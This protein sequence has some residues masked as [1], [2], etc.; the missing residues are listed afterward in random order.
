[1]YLASFL[2]LIAAFPA[3]LAILYLYRYHG[4]SIG[5]ARDNLLRLSVYFL[6]GVLSDASREFIPGSTLPF[7]G[8][9]ISLGMVILS[10]GHVTAVINYCPDVKSLRD[11]IRRFLKPTLPMFAYYA[12][13]LVA[14]GWIIASLL[15]PVGSSSLLYGDNVYV[16]FV[17][18][19]AYQT[20]TTVILPFLVAYPSLLLVLAI[21]RAKSSSVR[22]SLIVLLAGW[23]LFPTS[24]L[25]LFIQSD[26]SIVFSTEV[27]LLASSTFFLFCAYSVRGGS[28]IIRLLTSQLTPQP[29]LKTGQKYLILHDG[30]K[31]I[32]SFLSAS[33][34]SVIDAGGRV[35]LNMTGLRGGLMDGLSRGQPKFDNWLKSGRIVKWSEPESPKMNKTLTERFSQGPVALTFVTPLET[36]DLRDMRLPG[37]GEARDK[38]Q[39]VSQ[40]YLL[41]SNKAPR[42][43]LTEFLSRNGEVEVMNLSE[44]RD[45]FSTLIKTDH[46]RIQ[47]SRILVEYDQNSNYDDVVGRFFSEGASNAEL[48]AL[49]TAKSSKL[50]RTMKGNKMVKV[51]SA[52]SL[53]SSMDELQDG[54]IQVPDHELGLVAA[55]TSNL[56][57]NNPSTNSSFVF[58]SLP[59]LMTSNHWEQTYSG[60]KQLFELVSVPNATV[61][62]LANRDTFDPKLIGAIRGFFSIQLRL[63]S[64][65]LH[66]QKV[67]LS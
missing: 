16:F 19:S 31:E 3:L 47:G 4:N 55:V 23:I 60:I 21:N 38:N 36:E 43:L 67:S 26:P 13:N 29:V 53:V 24:Q 30:G 66:A 34:Q 39:P 27:T 5:L 57:E 62:F 51:I 8:M 32:V 20:L 25:A 45:T 61:I 65:G 6:I 22:Q 56:I 28:G 7:Y 15:T 63:D 33:F 48:C 41:E 40:L 52:S 58:D 11:S 64:A 49:F 10:F 37:P 35:V 17:L 59:E 18:P 1:M 50:Y 12:F 46:Q 54:E 42:P 2:D 44:A 9:I 14:M